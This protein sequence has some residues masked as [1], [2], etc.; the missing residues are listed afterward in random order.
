MSH[1]S[2]EVCNVVFKHWPSICLSPSS[3]KQ[4]VFS[5]NSTVYFITCH[6]IFL[7]SPCF[8]QTAPSVPR[9][10]Q[11]QWNMGVIQAKEAVSMSL[12]E[13]MANFAFLYDDDGPHLN[14]HIMEKLKPEP[15][16]AIEQET[17]SR[18]SPDLSLLLADPASD[19]T[20]APQSQDST[21]TGKKTLVPRNKLKMGDWQ[22]R[23]KGHLNDFLLTDAVSSK[24]M[25]HLQP[26]SQVWITQIYL[27]DK[28]L[29][30]LVPKQVL[31]AGK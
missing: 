6:T 11:V 26:D 21:S 17:G 28:G 15:C 18:L 23:G 3:W 22:K 27:L 20:A 7:F 30:C 13:R 29:C 31:K 10:L 8:V 14:P 19:P 1:A 2:D 12:D 25:L 4:R 5:N 24:E 9:K 16:S